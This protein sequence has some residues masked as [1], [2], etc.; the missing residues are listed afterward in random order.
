MTT[1]LTLSA[2]VAGLALVQSVFGVGVLVFGTP[3]LLLLGYPYAEVLA[4]LLPAS[5][6]I[7]ATQVATT[8]G[9]TLEPIRKKVL[10]Y[11]A[12]AVALGMVLV[13]VVFSGTLDIKPIVGGML[14]ITAII[15]L[16]A[17]LRRALG[18]LVRAR[19]SLFLAAMGVIHGLSNLGGGILTVIVASVHD[20]KHEVRRHIAFAYGLMASTQLVALWATKQPELIWPL[21]AVL[22][23]LAVTVFWFVGNRVFFAARQVAYQG[24]LTGL[25]AL[26]GL[27]LLA[28]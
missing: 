6:A 28:S 5:L 1:V 10:V 19:L 26:F 8:G 4:Y 25:I 12:P 17:R 2:V 15:R 23:A 21:L 13:F 16:S 18:R 3:T 24:A 11:T 14:L 9:V 22:P 7:S 27:L 20:E